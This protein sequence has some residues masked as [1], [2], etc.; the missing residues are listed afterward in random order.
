MRKSFCSVGLVLGWFR[1]V[2][3]ALCLMIDLIFHSTSSLP[4]CTPDLKMLKVKERDDPLTS[5]D[6]FCNCLL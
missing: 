2:V 4:R 6:N 5:L 3:K 1:S